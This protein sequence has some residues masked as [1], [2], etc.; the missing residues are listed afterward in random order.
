MLLQSSEAPKELGRVKARIIK[1]RKNSSA[2]IAAFSQH[3]NYASKDRFFSC[4][5]LLSSSELVESTAALWASK[6]T[7]LFR[8]VLN[9]KDTPIAP[10]TH[11]KQ[12]MV[13]PQT[14]ECK[15]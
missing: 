3:T 14:L 15:S 9:E 6:S 2:H 4:L 8:M 7:V 12:E 5:T 11:K 1:R 10:R 13:L